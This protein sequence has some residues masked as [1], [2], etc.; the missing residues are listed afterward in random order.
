MGYH[1]KVTNLQAN[2]YQS[3]SLSLSP[4]GFPLKVKTWAISACAHTSFIHS[5]SLW[6]FGHLVNCHCFMSLEESPTFL[7]TNFF[8]PFSFSTPP[9][10]HNQLLLNFSIFFYLLRIS[11]QTFWFNFDSY[12]YCITYMPF[13]S[14]FFMEQNFIL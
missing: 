3:F 12:F 10:I 8:S 7:I 5:Q 4:D 2:S 6:V 13:Y 11:G 14:N 1:P 9:S